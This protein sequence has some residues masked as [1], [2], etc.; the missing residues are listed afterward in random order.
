MV[1]MVAARSELQPSWSVTGIT[2]TATHGCN[3][4]GKE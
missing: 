3:G 4:C 1:V 2:V